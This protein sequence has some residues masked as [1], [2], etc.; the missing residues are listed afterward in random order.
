MWKRM[1]QSSNGKHEGISTGGNDRESSGR[2]ADVIAQDNAGEPSATSGVHTPAML[3][4][5]EQIY[6]SGSVKPPR[7]SYGVLKVADMLDSPHLSGMRADSK[8][9][10]LL[11]ALDAGGAK[12]EDIL[13]DAI[14]RQRVL[15]DYEEARRRDLQRFEEAI[16]E[17][18]RALQAEMDRM[19]GQYMSRMQ[20]NLDEM[21]RAQESFRLWQKRKQH[22]ARRM[23]E[24]AEC[25]VPH[26]CAP[27]SAGLTV[28]LERAS[29]AAA[30]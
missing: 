13:Q 25:C 28:V 5:F 2:A 20:G 6:Q 9:A 11:M 7:L 4:D 22:E 15:N 27:I 23:A 1:L 17:Q 8:R 26:D 19:T 12:M 10:A 18:N 30:H 16:Q 29:S 21:A 3:A 14:V 24:A